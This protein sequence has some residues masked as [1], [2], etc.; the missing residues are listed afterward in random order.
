MIR[1]ITLSELAAMPA[2]TCFWHEYFEFDDESEECAQ[3][4]AEEDGDGWLVRYVDLDGE[5]RT[6]C[7]TDCDSGII[8]LEND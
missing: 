2:G 4:L 8:L 1:D 7:I 5:E 3:V 6:M